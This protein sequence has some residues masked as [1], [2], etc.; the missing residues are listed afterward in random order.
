MQAKDEGTFREETV[1]L[2]INTVGDIG[3]IV[4]IFSNNEKIL[5]QL[6]NILRCSLR[7]EGPDNYIGT[8]ALTLYQTNIK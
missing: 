8:P 6:A 7:I 1:L 2:Q 5:I 4:N 3:H